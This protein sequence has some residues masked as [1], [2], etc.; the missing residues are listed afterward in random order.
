[1]C[2][3]CIFRFKRKLYVLSMPITYDQWTDIRKKKCIRSTCAQSELI[4]DQLVHK[5]TLVS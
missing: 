2:I 4:F 1:M 5:L 3:K